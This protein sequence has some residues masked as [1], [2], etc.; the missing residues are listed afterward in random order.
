MGGEFCQVKKG[1]GGA[2]E[3]SDSV[4]HC[5]YISKHRMHGNYAC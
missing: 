3:S 2:L 5:V 4:S 1:E